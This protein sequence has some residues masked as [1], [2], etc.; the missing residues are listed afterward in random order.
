MAVCI[1]SSGLHPFRRSLSRHQ[2]CGQSGP[3]ERRRKNE[4]FPS[5]QAALDARGRWS[6]QHLRGCS[7][8][9]LGIPVLQSSR[10]PGEGAGIWWMCLDG[11]AA[12]CALSL[13]GRG[14]LSTPASTPRQ[15]L[16][17]LVGHHIL[18]RV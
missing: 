16:P 4:C 8:G 11:R 13:G 14:L 5:Q 12:L 1:R 6:Q 9:S 15:H 2:C 3:V 10:K 18:S 17:H 7:A